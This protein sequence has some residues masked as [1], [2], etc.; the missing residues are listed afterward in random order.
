M[1]EVGLDVMLLSLGSDLPYLTG[2][3]AMATERL[4]MAVVPR[5][6][7]VVLHL[8]ELEA[9][10]VEQQ[11]EFTIA[12][13]EETDDPV[14]LVARSLGA[15]E[16]I[17]IGDQTWSRFLLRLSEELPSA[18]FESA[19]PVMSKL[20]IRKDAAEVDLLRT[21][22]VAADRVAARLAAVRF[23]GRTERELATEIAAMT[24]DE[25]HDHA[26]FTIVA[27]GPNGASPHHEPGTRAIEPGDACV[28]DFGGSV[29]G[30]H[31]DTT[32]TFHVGEATA[33]YREVF[34]VL[35]EAQRIGTEAAR[36]GVAAEQVDR[37]T[38]KVIE[39]AGYGEY[40]FHRTGHGIGLDGHE[41]PY[42]VEGNSQVLEEGMCF[43]IEPGIYVP[44]R[45][46]MRIEDIV[47][48][49]ADGAEP[50]N[51]SERDLVVVG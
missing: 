28:V 3:H 25:G 27:S 29:G 6:G 10:R 18:R 49:G 48:L 33:E 30:Y 20:R 35:H 36:P 15:A 34:A 45:F 26:T 13:W 8:P 1:A 22:G 40:F 46:G 37:A 19:T 47:A 42:L 43:S 21:A 24:V 51:R 14:S 11:P 12:A 17:A 41:D 23:S 50:L 32:R 7:E 5:D 16:R 2:Y 44:G 4:T 38:R 31:S 9:P 39:D